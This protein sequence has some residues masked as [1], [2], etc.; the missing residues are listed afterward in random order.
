MNALLPQKRVLKSSGKYK[1]F[2]SQMHYA[3]VVQV[4]RCGLPRIGLTAR[5]FMRSTRG[6]ICRAEKSE[7][8]NKI[9]RTTLAI[10]A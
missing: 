2:L 5:I 9:I 4:K 6:L 10:N 1:N 8:E 3:L 7:A